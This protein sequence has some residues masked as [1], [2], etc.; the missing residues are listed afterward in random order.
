MSKTRVVGLDLGSRCVRAAEVEIHTGGGAGPRV[1]LLRVG[2][3]PVDAAAMRDGEVVR[4]AAVT[5]ALRTLWRSERFGCKDVVLGVG[6]QRVFVRDLAVPPAPLDQ[7]RASLRFG[8]VQDLLPV[9]VEDCLLDFH[10]VGDAGEDGQVRGMLVAVPEETV[11]AN[12]AAVAAAGLRTVRVDLNAFGLLRALIHGALREEVVG[13]VDLGAAITDVV[14]ADRGLLRMYRTLPTGSAD[15]TSAVREALGVPEQ[16]AEEIKR[17]VGVVDPAT[18]PPDV[19]PAASVLVRRAQGL[20]ESLRSSFA[21]YATSAG[22]PVDRMLLVGRGSRIPGLGQFL[23]TTLGLP[24][25]FGTLDSGLTVARGVS[26]DRLAG[27]LGAVV[28]LAVGLAE[29]VAA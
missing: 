6:N 26:R 7:I 3:Q 22:R 21:Y 4:P 25:A 27:D 12:T 18:V 15:L 24:A 29:G 28:P 17:T 20:A 19:A 14:V 10:P 16:R 9:R 1:R 2:E 8:P 23:A 11:E 5:S 13:I